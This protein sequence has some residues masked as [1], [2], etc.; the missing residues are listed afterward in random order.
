M[1]NNAILPGTGICLADLAED[2]DQYQSRILHAT[3]NWDIYRAELHGQCA[4]HKAPSAVVVVNDYHA[5]CNNAKITYRHSA[6]RTQTQK[7]ET[8][9]MEYGY[10]PCGSGS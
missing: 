1:L 5:Q 10:I 6:L 7:T 2:H 4:L 9:N 3:C 8:P